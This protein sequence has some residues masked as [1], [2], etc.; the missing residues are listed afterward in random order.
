MTDILLDQQ[1]G[2]WVVVEANALKVAATDLLLDSPERRGNRPGGFRRAL[3]HDQNDGLTINFNRDYTGG[4]TIENALVRLKVNQ[5]PKLPKEG[6]I[7]ELYLMETHTGVDNVEILGISTSL[8][9]CVSPIGQAHFGGATW[10]EIPLG[11]SR[12]GG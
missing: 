11:E 5:G 1:N 12:I 10:R 8:W 7:G 2:Q 6:S 3:V 9:L 4:V